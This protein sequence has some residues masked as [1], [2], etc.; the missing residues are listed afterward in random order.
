MKK[1]RKKDKKRIV[2]RPLSTFSLLPENSYL[3]KD[4][5]LYISENL[6]FLATRII[7]SESYYEL[8]WIKAEEVSL[9][10]SLIISSHPEYGKMHLFPARWPFLVVDE[11]QDLS[12][13]NELKELHNFLKEEIMT[14]FK[15]STNTN[16]W[17]ELPPII[18]ERNYSFNKNIRLNPEY[19]LYLFNKIDI[20][21]DLMIRGLLHLLKSAML[22]CLSRSFIDTACLEIYVS[23]ES[24]LQIIL[25]KLKDD[26]MVNPSNKDASDYLLEAF[27]EPYRL[28]AYYEEFYKDRI[29][30]VHPK[31]RYGISK[32]VPLYVDDLYMLYNDLLRNYEFLITSKANCYLEYYE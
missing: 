13:I 10:S 27:D 25:S 18:T 15:S 7:E 31:N 1:A 6:S 11:D 14:Q 4:A 26:G 21:D 23:L 8:E 30:T 22:K 28:A 5:S 3:N 24:T 16:S 2:L 17:E 20:N 29:K 12:K 32:F 9:M 19:Q